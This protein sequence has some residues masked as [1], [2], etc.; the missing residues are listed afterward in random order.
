M[1]TLYGSLKPALQTHVE[2]AEQREHGHRLMPK[3][4]ERVTTFE[5]LKTSAAQC[6]SRDN[7]RMRDMAAGLK[8]LGLDVPK[9][10]K[11][12]Q[13]ESKKQNEPAW[14]R[15]VDSRAKG[16][17]KGGKGKSGGG[18]RGGGKRGGGKGGNRGQQ[19]PNEADCVAGLDGET[20]SHVQC[21]ACLEWGHAKQKY[22]EWNCP[23]CEDP[24]AKPD[25][26]GPPPAP[27]AVVEQVTPPVAA[28]VV[29]INALFDAMAMN[30]SGVDDATVAMMKQIYSKSASANVNMISLSSKPMCVVKSSMGKD[31]APAGQN[32]TAYV[33]MGAKKGTTAETINNP[34]KRNGAFRCPR[35]ALRS[36]SLYP[37][38]RI[39]A[40]L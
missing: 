34:S 23:K 29:D 15:W 30:E 28:P 35:S 18:K 22:G 11:R 20:H 8:S 14:T 38:T 21:Y 13:N 12:K 9:D 10:P 19:P 26:G 2:D 27:Q 36:P 5:E 37:H 4:G 17:K 32:F 1:Y 25:T 33:G 7:N 16:G 39:L 40:A 6:E 3:P 24:W 31:A